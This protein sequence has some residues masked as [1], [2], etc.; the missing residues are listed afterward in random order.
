MNA[1]KGTQ[2]KIKIALS[3]II[4]MVIALALNVI[5]VG[6]TGETQLI[7]DQ[8]SAKPGET[9]ALNVVLNNAPDIKAMSVSN[10]TY[11][12]TKATLTNVEWLCDAEIRNWNSSQ[13]RGVLTFEENTDAN[14]PVLRMT[15]VIEDPVNDADISVTCAITVMR[16]DDTN[17][18]V[19]VDTEIVPGS[20][21]IR[22]AIRGDVDGNEKLNSNDAV[23]LLYHVM[24]G[25][26]D[27]PINQN[28]DMDGNGKVNSNDAVY[29]L[30]RVMFG[31]ED[32]PLYAKCTHSMEHVEAKAATCE[33]TG[34]SEY[35]H[36]SSCGKYFSDAEGKTEIAENSWVVPAKGHTTGEAVIENR[37]EASCTE[38]GSYDEVVYCTV[39][40]TEIS[41][42][43]KEISAKGHTMTAT[44][45]KA[46]SCT[47]TGNSAYWHCSACGKYFSDADGKTEIAENSWVI[48]AKGHTHGEAVIENRVEP[49]CTEKGSYDEVVYCTVC[50]TEI[51]RRQKE[52]SAKG[53]TM[54]ATV[55]KAA[56]CTEA[57]NSAYWHCSVCDKYFSDADGKTEIAEN[58][59]VV[60]AK[61]HTPGEAGI[62]NRV[63]P[64]CTEKG[65]YD[66]V[67]YCTVCHTEIS[68]TQKEISAKGHT[69]TATV[70]KAASC[71]EAGNSAYWYCSVCG[72]YF[73]DAD[74]KT[75][76]AENSWIIP[77]TGHTLTAISAKD[78][79]C[80]EAGNSAYW[81]C[82][83]CDKY[84]SDADGKTEIAENS[85]IIP[86]KGHTPGEAVIENRV[87]PSCTEK[88]S[89]DEVVYCTVCHTEISRTQKEIPAKGHTMTA[90]VA[91][92]ASCIEAGNS[93]YWHCSVCGKYFSDAE[94]KTEIVENSW[95]VPAKGHT[96]GETV[97]ENRVEPSCTEKGSYDEV[98]YCTVCHAEISRTQ[99]EISAKGH[100]YVDGVCTICGEKYYSTGLAY[101]SNGDGTCY[102]SGMG[103]C[104]DTDIV[105]PPTSPAGDKVTKITWY[106]FYKGSNLTS[107]T[108]PSSVTNIDSGA[109]LNCI[110]LRTITLPFV[111]EKVD[112]TGETHFGYI[113]GADSY[114]DYNSCIPTSLKS[115][116]ITGGSEI[117][118]YAF[119]DRSNLTSII[120]PNSL[121]SIGQ[122]AFYGCS[123]LTSIV[124]PNSVT[125]I[126]SGAFEG[127]RSL[128]NIVIP[129]GVTSIGSSAFQAC[130][131]LMSIVIPNSVTSIGNS[132]FS[133]CSSL[134]SIVIPDSVTSIGNNA[135]SGCGSLTSIT[136]PSSVTSIHNNAFS[137][138]TDIG[139]LYG[140]IGSFAEQYAM[141][142]GIEF[143]SLETNK[144]TFSLGLKYSNNA[145]GSC[146]VIGKGTFSGA[147]L[148]IPEYAPGGAHV[149]AIA[150]SAFSKCSELTSIILPNSI[151][152]I[153]NYS[154][155][156]CREITHIE[157]PDSVVSMG[158]WAFSGCT[159]LRSVIF[160]EDCQLITVQSKLF[161]NTNLEYIIIPKNIAEIS[162]D[163]FDNCENFGAIFVDENN[164]FFTA[165]GG[166]LY[167]KEV[168]KILFVLR[169]MNGD[170]KIPEGVRQIGNDA[171]ANC[172]GITRISIPN[173]VTNIG[174]GA[175]RGCSGVVGITFDENS[176]LTDIGDYAFYNCS[177]IDNIALPKSVTKI[178]G[179]AFKGCSNIT[180]I[181]IPFVGE[182]ANGTGKTH[183]GYL[184]G[185]YDYSYNS[186]CVPGS[187]KSVIIKSGN[188][189]SDN[190]FYGCNNITR[191]TIPES[192]TT[193]GDDAFSECSDLTSIMFEECSLL[194]SIGYY[195]FYHCS[196]LKSIWLPNEVVYIHGNAFH[197]CS[198]LTF[199]AIPSSVTS[200]EVQAFDAC[201]KL[202][203]V[204][205]EENSRLESIG[206]YAFRGC[207][208]L[209]HM[210]IPSS[211]INIGEGALSECGALVSITIPFVGEKAD[212]TGKT[213]LGYLFG[214]YNYIGQSTFVPE[215][216]KTVEITDGQ[217]IENEA[218]YECSNIM[219]VTISNSV[220]RIGE[221]AFYN[222]RSLTSVIFGEN[223]QLTSIGYSA[224][225]GCRSLKNVTIPNSVT[226]ISD[227]AFKY[228]SNLASIA[229][230]ENGQLTS[231]GEG[232]FGDC[233]SLTSI[234]IP[235]SVTSIGSS[236]FSGC[237]SLT[238]IVIPNSV[239][240]IGGWAFYECGNLT[241]I[242]IPSSITNIGE[243]VFARCSNLQT[244]YYDGTTEQWAAIA[245]GGVNDWWIEE[246]LN[247]KCV[248][249]FF[250]GE[251]NVLYEEA[252]AP[253]TDIS[254]G[255]HVP[256]KIGY[257]F[258]GWDK[259]DDVLSN[260]T[261]HISIHPIFEPK[262][263]EVSFTSGL[264]FVPTIN[265]IYIKYGKGIYRD[266]ECTYKTS[267]ITI[268][269]SYDCVFCGCWYD[270]NLLDDVIVNKNGDILFDSTYF[271]N[272]ITLEAIW[273]YPVEIVLNNYEADV[274]GTEKIF[275][276]SE[277]N[278]YYS[279]FKCDNKIGSI[280]IPQKAG[281]EF[282]GYYAHP[283]GKGDRIV[284]EDGNIIYSYN[285]ET[286]YA[287]WKPIVYTLTLDKNTNELLKN[288]TLTGE[289]VF[290]VDFTST[291]LNNILSTNDFDYEI[292]GWYTNSKYGYKVINPDGTFVYNNWD[293][294]GE[295]TLYAHWVQKYPDYVYLNNDNFKTKFGPSGKY[296]LI[297]D[298]DLSGEINGP[299]S[300]ISIFSGELDGNG[301]SILNFTYKFS[302]DNYFNNR[303]EH[304]F[305][306]RL[307]GTV[308]NLTLEVDINVY[309]YDIQSDLYVG[310]LC[311]ILDGGTIDNVNVRG[312]IY[313]EHC[314]DTSKIEMAVANYLMPDLAKAIV[315]KVN[316][317]RCVSICVGGLAGYMQ[318]GKISHSAYSNFDGKGYAKITGVASRGGTGGLPCFAFVGGIAGYQKGG[319]IS[320]CRIEG[321]FDVDITACIK[322]NKGWILF[323][324]EDMYGYLAGI[325]GFTEAYSND[326]DNTVFEGVLKLHKL[327]EG[328]NEENH[329]IY[330]TYYNR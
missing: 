87:E 156:G 175:F 235:N 126:G 59:W 58:S 114:L 329:F 3:V 68:R 279:S 182:K 164:S 1:S 152:D 138:N 55:A 272:D 228:C 211:V 276:L 309:K 10:I 316:D 102:V 187:L 201:S 48:P 67:I 293:I 81:H 28:G 294:D 66:E 8:V 101:T 125:S 85:W 23:Y 205:F 45:A 162:I 249:T 268:P 113:F 305:F 281:F 263:I 178:G 219:R 5:Q 86:A 84:F 57:G 46:A 225:I 189:I 318:S 269:S 267:K 4:M 65:S 130:I 154:F 322:G 109:F 236:A 264:S 88:G 232:A 90:T 221:Y 147:E 222:C 20:I 274:N 50:H 77:A 206:S 330:D 297:S 223:S 242:T 40:H 129:D 115:V 190:A 43:Q 31:E 183:F 29:L 2:A 265:S 266:K 286:L 199:I 92:A 15:F 18:E 41:R 314:D 116:I 141:K 184:F 224:F 19:P 325:A 25:N 51:S 278:E 327:S 157:I 170:F 203:T 133:E 251:G 62:E 36:C 255:Y 99:K 290:N 301:H 158:K 193:I 271:A 145:D 307:K 14:G 121:I 155:E 96:P 292:E 202:S 302:S 246:K 212:G 128:T 110:N 284:D 258:V 295:I 80:T 259:S 89:Y 56:T 172:I 213:H 112:G 16:M 63:E 105:I 289:S 75:E 52:I 252:V 174:Q 179:D 260:I 254:V 44:F 106:A 270:S 241:S 79:T 26:E 197:G 298:I 296:R 216:L 132:T 209:T 257:V 198:S 17:D 140:N 308:K 220:T 94:G 324:S 231:I 256:E 32:Y 261:N 142:K 280:T 248:V 167:N 185:A 304:G 93:E 127:C 275:Y 78:A 47:E 82:S 312:K 100:N 177:C 49:S 103:T 299:T 137:G 200:I 21:K 303:Y 165:T 11:D 34:N 262:I 317:S 287:Y 245:I 188:N 122:Y 196:S 83:V 144:P 277:F 171:F 42:T 215:S 143:I 243:Y 54:T 71:T 180:S 208:N 247:L 27:Y 244:V 300:V 181:T 233:S 214:T 320:W 282:D 163:A 12:T 195:A 24:F 288:V 328:N 291:S 64:S 166:A 118:D 285:S 306:G 70:A 186:E 6:A 9:V 74:G 173:S 239:T 146:T 226:S 169:T 319:E 30:Y 131:N 310:G 207:S 240:S 323:F 159:K 321:F 234:V 227:Y 149:T 124:I 123:S 229:F 148:I 38:K 151:T 120:L 22:N 97:I 134:T 176:Q 250:D 218:F 253:G 60:P 111:G 217:K 76:I 95:V 238:S 326:K 91:K 283:E 35:W 150:D 311:G 37:V 153:G 135:F 136:I 69:M 72:K 13:G 160:G 315:K 104:K 192:V 139:L 230:S 53:H 119:W 194:T 191:I 108:I 33:E 204:L 313:G 161:N 273:D 210:T 73:S 61:G 39:C 168:T 117:G 98:V 107:I 7:I 237:S